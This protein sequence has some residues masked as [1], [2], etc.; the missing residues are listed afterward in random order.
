MYKIN[1]SGHIYILILGFLLWRG[2][3]F[4]STTDEITSSCLFFVVS[5]TRLLGRLG[6]P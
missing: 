3:E 6:L 1:S 5:L 4:A 2:L